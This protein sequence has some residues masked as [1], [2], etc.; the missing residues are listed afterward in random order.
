MKRLFNFFKK[1]NKNLYSQS[2]Q[3]QFAFNLCGYNGFYLE[4]GAHDPIIN[5]NTYNLE[6]KCNWQGLSV[7]FDKTFEHSWR[8]FPQRKNQVL[9]KDA[10]EIDY[11]ELVYQKKIPKKIDY[12]SCDIEPPENT[13][14]I[15][16]KIILSDI[17]FKFISFEH[18]KYESGDKYEK[19]S[20]DFL[21]KHSYRIAVDE[22]YSREKKN[23]IYET[24]FIN[25]DMRFN[26]TEYKDWKEKFYKNAIF[27]TI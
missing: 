1:N 24:W 27:N 11:K 2:G 13:F 7:E 21:K 25:N 6:V 18:D 17:S 3:D 23:K 12:L 4:I 5:S 8:S 10:F 15:L 19:L 14:E 20:K 22:V 9:W 26:R 16:K